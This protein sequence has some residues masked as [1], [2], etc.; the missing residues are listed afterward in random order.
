MEDSLERKFTIQLRQGI[1]FLCFNPETIL[2][3][4][5]VKFADEKRNEISQGITYPLLIQLNDV[6]GSNKNARKLLSAMGNNGITAIAIVTN[7]MIGKAIFNFVLNFENPSVPMKLFIDK[8][9]A[10][11]WLE[12]FSNAKMN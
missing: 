5:L 4:E 8:T 11:K 9:K 10:I 6:F 3:E 1:L 7:N 2:T 12:T